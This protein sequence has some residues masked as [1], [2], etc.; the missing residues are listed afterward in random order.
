MNDLQRQDFYIQLIDDC[1]AIVTE[2]VF[3]S[4]WALVEGHWLLGQRI[5]QESKKASITKLTASLAV[6]LKMSERTLWYA[7]QFYRQYPQLDTVPEGKNISWN[8]LITKYLPAPKEKDDHECD[9][10]DE[11]YERCKICGKKRKK[12]AE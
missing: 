1:Q 10:E 2:S 8:K 5:E 4:R 7:V 6:A 11:I 3:A 9:W 12:G